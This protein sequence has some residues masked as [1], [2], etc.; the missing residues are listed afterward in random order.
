MEKILLI[1]DEPG[2]I[3]TLSKRLES[4]GYDV[5]ISRNG[6]DGL[7]EAINHWYDLVILDIMLP[8]MDGFDICR[9]LRRHKEHL[10]IL[11]LT[12]RGQTI[13]KVLGFKL[14]ADDYQTKPFQMA[15]LVARIEA[16]LRRSNHGENLASSSSYRFAD[17]EVNFRRAEMRRNRE[18]VDCSAKEFQL[19]RHFILNKGQVLSREE[20]LNTVWGYET[21]PNTR[22]VDVHVARLRQ[23]IEANPGK[24]SHLLTV[25]NMG[26]RFDG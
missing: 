9:D 25:H 21:V 10:P 2:L 26:Y 20:I 8:G 3:A 15:E 24:P 6:S 19:L 4:H 17:I 12:A 7:D 13:D 1:E 14:G 11:M 22:T 16:L 23:K 18:V 5:S